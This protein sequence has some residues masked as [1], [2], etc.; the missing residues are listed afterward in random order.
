M[1]INKYL[2]LLSIILIQLCNAQPVR[3]FSEKLRFLN[4]PKFSAT[5]STLNSL[6]SLQV[7]KNGNV[8]WM[9]YVESSGGS[10]VTSVNGETGDVVL[11][12]PDVSDFVPYTGASGNID[13]GTNGL[14]SGSLISGIIDAEKLRINTGF[15]GSSCYLSDSII[16][17][18]GGLYNTSTDKEIATYNTFTSSFHYGNESIVIN[19]STNEIKIK[20]NGGGT[21]LEDNDGGDNV[22]TFKMSEG[23]IIIHQDNAIGSS[24]LE[25][26]DGNFHLT[27]QG[28]ARIND[29][30]ILTTLNGVTKG[31]QNST[32]VILTSSNLNSTYPTAITGFKVYCT[33][34]AAGK[35]VYEKTVTGWIGYSCIIP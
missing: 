33:S 7:D 32:T 16:D 29:N 8:V 13:I 6:R 11:D 30:E 9:P 20:S 22:T 19:H 5:S 2:I 4:V 3:E 23:K 21:Q 17:T 24:E 15:G 25:M 31:V 34:I 27:I 1:K 35:M 28:D 10:A 12:I 14:F 18:E 26:N